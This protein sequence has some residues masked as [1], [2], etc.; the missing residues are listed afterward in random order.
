V[1][2]DVAEE[3]KQKVIVRELLIAFMV[4]VLFLLVGPHLIKALQISETSLRLA[5]GIILFLIALKMIFKGQEER[6]FVGPI[7]QEPLVVPLAIPCI[8]GPSA[9]ATVMLFTAQEPGRWPEWLLALF[10]AWFATSSILL[11]SARLNRI[12]GERGLSA[13][14]NLMGLVLTTLAVEMLLQGIR[15]VLRQPW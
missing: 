14:Q 13:L 3:R 5:G 6:L 7:G 15:A 10:L 2:K 8:A 4:L 12:L 11:F 1:L 9:I